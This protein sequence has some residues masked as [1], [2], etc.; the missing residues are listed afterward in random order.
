MNWT[1]GKSWFKL[2]VN[3][4]SGYF[5]HQVRTVVHLVFIVKKYGMGP[6]YLYSRDGWRRCHS[7]VFIHFIS[8]WLFEAQTAPAP[9]HKLSHCTMALLHDLQNWSL[10][11]SMAEKTF[12]NSRKHKNR[13]IRFFSLVS[14]WQ[15]NLD[16]RWKLIADCSL[17]KCVL[18]INHHSELSQSYTNWQLCVKCIQ[19]IVRKVNS[20]SL[21]CWSRS[22]SFR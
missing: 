11:K 8:E 13:W 1:K 15:F 20:L 12:A 2:R 3:G 21:F 9:T 19:Q 17:Y 5:S 7:D 4:P 10:M 22:H 14:N 6:D 18:G 16:I